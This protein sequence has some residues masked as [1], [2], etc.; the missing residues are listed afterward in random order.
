MQLNRTL[1][2]N[3]FKACRYDGVEEMAAVI[4]QE[5]TEDNLAT[6]STP[7]NVNSFI[8]VLPHPEQTATSLRQQPGYLEPV[9]RIIIERVSR[10]FVQTG[11][12]STFMDMA[13]AAPISF[14]EEARKDTERWLE[15]EELLEGLKKDGAE[16]GLAMYQLVATL[17]MLRV[18]MHTAKLDVSVLV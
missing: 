14:R 9:Q 7:F 12:S 3:E 16:N 2:M 15:I 10:F 1:Y 18:I 11:C 8:G 13:K 5:I 4:F 6:C 17:D